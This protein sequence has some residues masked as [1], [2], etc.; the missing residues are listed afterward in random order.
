MLCSDELE[1]DYI[2]Q[3]IRSDHVLKRVYLPFSVSFLPL[4]PAVT[5][6]YGKCEEMQKLSV[7]INKT[8]IIWK[9]VF[10]DCS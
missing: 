4:P 5:G 7:H 10:R 2:F 9:T 8:G 3:S 1:K 6:N